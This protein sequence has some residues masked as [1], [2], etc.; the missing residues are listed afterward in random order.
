MN[1]FQQIADV[2]G[3]T[4]K[5]RRIDCVKTTELSAVSV[6]F[7]LFCGVIP[8]LFKRTAFLNQ[9]SI[10]KNNYLYPSKAQAY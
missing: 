3:V 6:V 2:T 9:D 5:K 4:S 8:D 1:D 10:I 7:N